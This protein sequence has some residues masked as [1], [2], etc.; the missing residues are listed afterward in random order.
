MSHITGG[1]FYEN[2]PRMLKDGQ[3]VTID[4]NSY[5]SKPI[6]DLICKTGN[7]DK[8]EMMQCLNYG[9]RLHSCPWIR[10]MWKSTVSAG[11]NQ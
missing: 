8:K 7:I 11:G 9:N 2:V 3:G 5:P 1:G 10:Q 6:F 4:L